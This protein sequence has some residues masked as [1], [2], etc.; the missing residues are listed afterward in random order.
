LR[1]NPALAAGI[2]NL[3]LIQS[4]E[5]IVRALESPE[6]A[7]AILEAPPGVRIRRL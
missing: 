3:E 7:G 4:I 5:E 2:D 1:R 6:A